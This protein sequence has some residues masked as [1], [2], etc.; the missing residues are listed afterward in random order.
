MRIVN[1]KEPTIAL[2]Y[3]LDLGIEYIIIEE[4]YNILNLLG[5]NNIDFTVSNINEA[6]RHTGFALSEDIGDVRFLEGKSILDLARLHLKM[7]DTSTEQWDIWKKMYEEILRFLVYKTIPPSERTTFKLGKRKQYTIVY[8]SEDGS[9]IESLINRV[10]IDL[11]DNAVIIPLV[12]EI[13]INVPFKPAIENLNEYAIFLGDI[14]DH[15]FFD[16]TNSTDFFISFKKLINMQND[17]IK[18]AK[19][20]LTDADV[21]ARR[22]SMPSY[23]FFIETLEDKPMCLEELYREAK[24]R[25]ANWEELLIAESLP[26]AYN[27]EIPDVEINRDNLSSINVKNLIN[28]INEN[29]PIVSWNKETYDMLKEDSNLDMED[30]DI[31]NAEIILDNLS[32][33]VT[34]YDNLKEI[35][36][37]RSLADIIYTSELEVAIPYTDDMEDFINEIIFNT[38]DSDLGIDL[39]ANKGALILKLEVSDD[40]IATAI[41]K[42]TTRIK[43]AKNKIE[44]EYQKVTNNINLSKEEIGVAARK[45]DKVVNDRFMSLELSSINYTEGALLKDLISLS[46]GKSQDTLLLNKV[47]EHIVSGNNIFNALD[48]TVNVKDQVEDIQNAYKLLIA[49]VVDLVI[50]SVLNSCSEEY[51]QLINDWTI[52]RIE[53]QEVIHKMNDIITRRYWDMVEMKH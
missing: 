26:V 5:Q 23:S 16:L 31:E 27:T 2:K 18:E 35:V 17:S 10:K 19:Y 36:K 37:F 39:N 40:T 47:R 13:I 33:P 45:I 24:I 3:N 28:K 29:K 30:I 43:S 12:E 49:K 21:K 41:S 4:I 20:R 42:I 22:A 9:T 6:I 46:K 38:D 44:Q 52:G 53:E 11:L 51:K 1:S 48:E 50:N 15:R 32:K 14:R 7:G 34:S 8:R 25:Y